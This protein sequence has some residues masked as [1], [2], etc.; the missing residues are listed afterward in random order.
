[1]VW[2][3]IAHYFGLSLKSRDYY[4][5]E[6]Q[7]GP[8]INPEDFWAGPRIMVVAFSGGEEHSSGS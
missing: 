5:P 8:E 6:A 3:K 1:M 4:R 7:P 2:S